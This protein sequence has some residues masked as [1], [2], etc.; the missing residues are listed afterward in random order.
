MDWRTTSSPS[1]NKPRMLCVYLLPCN[2]RRVPNL[3]PYKKSVLRGEC[4]LGQ[5][6]LL[7]NQAASNETMRNSATKM[8]QIYNTGLPTSSSSS[9]TLTRSRFATC[10]AIKGRGDRRH[11]GHRYSRLIIISTGAAEIFAKLGRTYMGWSLQ[12]GTLEGRQENA[13]WR[14]NGY[15]CWALPY[16][17]YKQ[18]YCTV[19]RFAAQVPR[20]GEARLGRA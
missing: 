19:G 11:M 3:S 6:E 7:Y 16:F 1:K 9:V 13:G 10:I 15:Y 12:G 8:M 17:R 18:R 20:T 14:G 2:T 4:P 5:Y